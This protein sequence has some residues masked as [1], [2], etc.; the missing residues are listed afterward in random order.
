MKKAVFCITS[1]LFLIVG[2][3]TK[4]VSHL[5]KAVSQMNLDFHP[6]DSEA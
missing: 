4:A 2:T 1:S 6:R 5:D 3:Q